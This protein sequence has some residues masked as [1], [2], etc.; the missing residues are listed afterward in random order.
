MHIKTAI[1]QGHRILYGGM[2][3][4]HV[5][6]REQPCVGGAAGVFD[7]VVGDE[8]NDTLR[9]FALVEDIARRLDA[10]DTPLVLSCCLRLAHQLQRVRPVWVAKDLADFGHAPVGAV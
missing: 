2:P 4:R 5:F 8:I 9:D 10:G 6:V 3:L 1:V 7:R